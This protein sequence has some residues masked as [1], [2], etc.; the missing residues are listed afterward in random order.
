M[1][2]FSAELPTWITVESEADKPALDVTV[3]V[4]PYPPGED[5]AVQVT[6]APLPDTVPPVTFQL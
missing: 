5:G 4:A 1:V 6:L 3:H 2:L